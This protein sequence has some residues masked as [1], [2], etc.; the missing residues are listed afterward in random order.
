MATKCFQVAGSSSGL[1]D[2][3]VLQGRTSA[4]TFI[5]TFE[6]AS[7]MAHVSITMLPGVSRHPQCGVD[8]NY[9]T[10]ILDRI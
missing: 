8:L 10:S 9:N 7:P 1:G 2:G 3:L 5:N 6:L 4:W